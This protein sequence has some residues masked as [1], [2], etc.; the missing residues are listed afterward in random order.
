MVVIQVSEPDR[1]RLGDGGSL[2]VQSPRAGDREAVPPNRFASLTLFIAIAAAPLPFASVNTTI[3]AFWCFLLGLGLVLASPQPLRAG[4]LALLGGIA[5][6]IACYGFV[7]HEQLSAH[8]WIASPNPIWAK[9]SA[10]LGQ[11]VAPSVS[12]IRGEPFYALGPSC[13]AMLALVLGLVIGADNNR[14]RQALL[15]MAW[16]GVAYAAYGIA[17]LL[18]DPNVILWHEKIYNLESLTA[19]FIN[20][21]TAAIYFGTCAIVW[22]VFLMARLREQLPAGPIVWSKAPRSIIKRTSGQFQIVTRF[23]MFFVCFAAMLMTGSRGGVLLS[24]FAM[25]IA[26]VLFFRKDLPRSM[27]LLLAAAAAAA[28]ALLLL[29]FLGGNVEQRIGVEGLEEQGR[30]AAYKSTLRIIADYPWFGTGLGT[31]AAVFPAYRSA[32]ISIIGIWDL[33]HSTPLELAAEL[34][35]PLAL[36]FAAAWI[37]AIV[38]LFRGTRRSRRDTVAPVA[39]LGV[40]LAALLHS[41]IDF[42]LQIPGFAI[43]VFAIVGVG[44]AQSFDTGP[45]RHYRKSDA[46]GTMLTWMHR[47]LSPGRHPAP[48]D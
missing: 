45:S 1:Q 35:L 17:M 42:S 14:A 29:H 4:H 24:M 11:P 30:L 32:D 37:V 18:F 8:P 34:G 13:A 2:R 38:V 22:L 7:L 31:F 27:N 20:R 43:V 5:C 23:L 40:A 41:S 33:A 3:V 46:Y 10:L 47:I 15:V 39:A 9:T 28:V 6:V 48:N 26:F 44:L 19:T 21:N 25:V 36:T 12:V 16:S